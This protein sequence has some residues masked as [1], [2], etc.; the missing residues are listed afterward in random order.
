MHS[1]RA[2]LILSHVLPM[3]VVLSLVG[4]LLAYLLETQVYLA[5]ASNELEQHA[6]L[7]ADLASTYPAIWAD[8]A[9]SQAFL[10][11]IG[12]SLPANVM[13][14]DSSGVLLASSQSADQARLGEELDLPGLDEVVRTGAIVR[15][16]Y[17][18]QPGTGAAEVLVPVIIGGRV[19]GVIRLTD[20]LS[21]VYARFSATRRYIL[22]VVAGGLFLGAA[23]GLALASGLERPLRR[24]T[25]AVADMAAGQPLGQLPEQGP[26]EVRLLLRAF[27]TLTE[28][29]Q[30]L[31]RARRRLLANLVHELGRPLGALL[32]A[33]QALSSGAVASAEERGELLRGMEG[34][35]GRLRRVLDD[36]T[37]L[38][39]A[40]LGT[41]ELERHSID[42]TA[43]L[44][45]T[46]GPWRQAAQEKG[47]AWTVECPDDL[48][49]ATVDPDRL[50]Q[51][52]G[53]LVSNAIKY[54]P[55]GGSVRVHAEAAD[56][57]VCIS[58]QDSGPGIPA[59]ERE[60][61][62]T[63]YHRVARGGRFP[64]GMG[65]G[66]SIARDLV[67]AHGGTIQVDSQPGSG[68]IFSIC[69]PLG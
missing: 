58:V 12:E 21:S 13:L 35:V 26:Q 40:S 16:D 8:R 69:L 51:A 7:V 66:L 11:L 47:I 33:I 17:G 45:Q 24:A 62:F 19:V 10:D 63:P 67:V 68:A 49:R 36:L 53:N 27:N 43:W 28:R 14:L 4:L 56:G 38:Y 34:E 59:E 52:L 15:A 9:R 3:L 60:H 31:E 57:Q 20:P 46:L 41:L 65:L 61:I 5:Q 22:W 54:T 55:R 42:L 30:S 32:S 18:E 1:L 6:L 25:G 2:R 64:Q 50:G 37:C 29:L 44:G 39:D 23:M 48:P